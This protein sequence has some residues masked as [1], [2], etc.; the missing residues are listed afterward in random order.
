MRH[1]T[2]KKFLAKCKKGRHLHLRKNAGGPIIVEVCNKKDR[3][4]AATPVYRFKE[5]YQ[6]IPSAVLGECPLGERYLL[7]KHPKG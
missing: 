4:L 6:K 5:F 7:E 1:I 3:V 2:H